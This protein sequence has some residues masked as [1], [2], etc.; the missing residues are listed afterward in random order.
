MEGEVYLDG[1]RMPVAQE[2]IKRQI[3]PEILQQMSV[4]VMLTGANPKLLDIILQTY[5]YL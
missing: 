1:Q 3:T 5:F 2:S 4:F